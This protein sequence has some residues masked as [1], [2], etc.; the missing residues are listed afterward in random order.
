MVKAD[1]VAQVAQRCGM[2]QNEAQKVVDTIFACL[3]DALARR[4]R[5]EVR[6]FASFSA[7]R[8]GGYTGRNP[9]TGQP[10]PV[11]PKW[12]IVF[13]PGSELRRRVD[14]NGQPG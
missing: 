14:G 11:Q 8:Y 6:G 3:G 5:I 10:I 12:G 7:K 4:E 13:R 2:K 1:L 9:R